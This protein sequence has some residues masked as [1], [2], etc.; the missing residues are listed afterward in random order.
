MVFGDSR[1]GRRHHDYNDLRVLEEFGKLFAVQWKIHLRR[2]AEFG[3]VWPY[4]R[5]GPIMNNRFAGIRNRGWGKRRVRFAL[6]TVSSRLPS[7]W[8]CQNTIWKW[9]KRV[10]TRTSLIN[11]ALWLFFLGK[12]SRPYAVIKDPTFIHFWKKSCKNWV[13]IEKSGYF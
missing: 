9:E 12:Y 3:N 2:V 1:I 13:K 6:I 10:I 8:F 7:A 11:V 4:R 5:P